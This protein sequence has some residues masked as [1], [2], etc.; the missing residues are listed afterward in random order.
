[1]NR[2][3]SKIAAVLALII[4]AMA[5]VAGGGVLLGRDP[6]YYVIDWLPVYN[7][8]A[9]VLTVIVAA[10]LL[11]R[12]SRYALAA[13]LVTFGAHGVVMLVIQTAYGEVVASD[14]IKAM[15][16]RLTVWTIVLVLFFLH[17]RRRQSVPA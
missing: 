13:A 7:F 10:P 12:E 2:K 17:L 15:T 3:L 16:V 8:I 11:W 4:G 14:S 6:G 1:M 5:I 9:G